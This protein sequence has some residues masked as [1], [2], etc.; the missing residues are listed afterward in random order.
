ME[1]RALEMSEAARG[2]CAEG[3]DQ[4]P[5]H[6]AVLRAG[7]GEHAADEEGVRVFRIDRDR[8]VVLRLLGEN[9]EILLDV[10][11]LQRNPRRAAVD[12]A[13]DRWPMALAKG[14][15]PEKLTE[16]IER[17]GLLP[18][19]YDICPVNRAAN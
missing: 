12:D 1:T 19:L 7:R 5:A 2:G 10:L 18:R 15:D 11:R 6:A 3:H 4:G 13:A 9:V 17:H 16:G 8:L 14:G